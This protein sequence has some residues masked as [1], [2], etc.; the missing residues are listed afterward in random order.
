MSRSTLRAAALLAV[1]SLG[2]LASQPA[3]AFRGPARE[4]GVRKAGLE[5]M[6]IQ[7]VHGFLAKFFQGSHTPP[8]GQIPGSNESD[9]GPGLCPVG[10]TGSKNGPKGNTGS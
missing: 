8:P 10:K 7:G 9:E 4:P 2:T 6:I 1:V 3:Y 5:R